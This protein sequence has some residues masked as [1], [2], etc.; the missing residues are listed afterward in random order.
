LYRYIETGE[1]RTINKTRKVYGLNSDGFC[2]PIWLHVK[3]NPLL[4]QGLSFL[5]ILR[6]IDSSK[7]VILVQ[8]NGVVDGITENL[9]NDL[10]IKDLKSMTVKIEQF[11]PEFSFVN[12]AFNIV[13]YDHLY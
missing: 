4:D 12:Q 1:S 5:S 3:I 2:F 13:A 10:R 8:E 7:R 6:P 11:S 9:A